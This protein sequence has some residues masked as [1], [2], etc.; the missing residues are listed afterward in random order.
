MPDDAATGPDSPADSGDGDSD[1]P[2]GSGDDD[3]DTPAGSGDGDSPVAQLAAGAGTGVVGRLGSKALSLVIEVLLTQ[4]LGPSR[5]GRYVLGKSVARIAQ[6]LAQL[7][8]TQGAVRYGSIH[9]EADDEDALAGVLTA[10]LVLSAGAGVVAAAAVFALAGP[11]ARSVFGDPALAAPLRWF[12]AAIPFYVLLEVVAA[13]FRAF[14]RID[15]E[16]LLTSGLRPVANLALVGGAFLLGYRLAGAVA[17]FVLTGALAAAVGLSLLLRVHNAP[18]GFRAGWAGARAT[19]RKLL[20]YSLPMM[21]VS[22]SFLVATRTDRLML[23]ALA[24]SESV[25]VYNVAATVSLQFSVVISSL[26]AIFKP[27]IADVD[28]NRDPERIPELYGV[29][30]KWATYGTVALF[31]VVALYSARILSVFGPEFT[32]ARDVLAVLPLMYVGGAVFGPCGALLA[33]TG[34]ERI[35]VVNGVALVVLNLVGNYLLIPEYGALGAAVA[36][37]LAGTVVNVVQVS[38]VYRFYG[39]HPFDPAHILRIA[40]TVAVVAGVVLV[41]QD[42]ALVAR[43]AAC[44]ALL[45][46]IAGLFY[47]QIDPAERDLIAGVFAEE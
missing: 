24:T 20:V 16:Q 11:L 7:G 25:G 3:S 45:A 44:V 32:A 28:E 6:R 22:M 34:R 19:A 35:E 27:I 30:A 12:A 23:G 17:G 41:G 40:V 43:T 21:L 10:S 2:A 31:V 8:L 36:V 5:Y 1:S 47:V 13:Y 26:L 15:R 38:L 18:V 4:F 14:K 33:M 39:F 42:L 29:V 46:G 9:Y 37:V